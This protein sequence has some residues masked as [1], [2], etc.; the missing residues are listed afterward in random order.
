MGIFK[1]KQELQEREQ[2]YLA[3]KLRITHIQFKRNVMKVKLAAQLFSRSVATALPFCKNEFKLPIFQG[4]DATADM[5]LL[6]NDLFDIQ[7]SK[8]HGYRF[9]RTLNHDNAPTVFD[10]LE[11]CK[12]FLVTV[13]TKKK[14]NL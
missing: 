2:F 8:V 14:T 3:N 11:Q 13:S 1:K 12:D 7:D 6:I 4:V 10:K 5:L 9:K